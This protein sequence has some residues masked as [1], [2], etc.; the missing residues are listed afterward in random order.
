MAKDD[1]PGIAR[2]STN[3]GIV[4]LLFLISLTLEYLHG[5][6]TSAVTSLV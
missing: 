6:V 3:H 2:R 4:V 5:L 1:R